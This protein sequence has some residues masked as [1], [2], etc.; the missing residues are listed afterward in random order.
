MSVE[1]YFVTLASDVHTYF[2]Y[3]KIISEVFQMYVTYLKKF[4]F[5]LSY[6][7]QINL[8]LSEQPALL[9]QVK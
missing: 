6:L 8:K 1:R 7:R 3:V 2:K 9:W 4:L 5:A